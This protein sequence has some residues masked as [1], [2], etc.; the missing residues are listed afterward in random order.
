M[1]QFN[2]FGFWL[3]LP[4]KSLE[5]Q[6]TMVTITTVTICSIPWL[7][8]HIFIYHIYGQLLALVWL[9]LKTSFG[10]FSIFKRTTVTQSNFYLFIKFLIEPLVRL[11]T[12]FF[13]FQHHQFWVFEKPFSRQVWF[14]T[15][16]GYLYEPGFGASFSSRSSSNR[17]AVASSGF[18][19]GFRSVP[20][21]IPVRGKK[22]KSKF[23]ACRQSRKTN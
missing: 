22:K 19:C 20:V 18:S 15:R 9:N 5:M 4:T 13:T 14:Q 10:R 11:S 3:L 16:S 7:G 21:P 6:R 8:I 23:W 1:T 2:T 17:R 12:Q